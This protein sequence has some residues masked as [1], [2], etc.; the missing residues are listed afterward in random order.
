[1]SNPVFYYSTGCL[2]SDDVVYFYRLQFG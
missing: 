1:M 2:N